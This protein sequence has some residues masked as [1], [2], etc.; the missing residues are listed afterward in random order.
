MGKSDEGLGGSYEG[1]PGGPRGGLTTT[2]L[3]GE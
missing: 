2:G 1:G 3:E